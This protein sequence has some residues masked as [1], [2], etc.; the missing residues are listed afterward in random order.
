MKELERQAINDLIRV[1]GLI[2]EF[3]DLKKVSDEARF[4][5]NNYIPAKTVISEKIMIY[6]STLFTVA[7][8]NS[9]SNL[10]LLTVDEAKNILEE[11]KQLNK[12]LEKM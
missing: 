7:Y 1:Y 2:V 4:I 12:T 6:V 3:E 5:Y 8:P 11:L 9:E 10:N